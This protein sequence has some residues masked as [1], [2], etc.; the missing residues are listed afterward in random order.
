MRNISISIDKGDIMA[1]LSLAS[2]YAGARAGEPDEY[3]R[4]AATRDDRLMLERFWREC[5]GRLTTALR[6]V[7]AGLTHTPDG[8]TL[9]LE[10]SDSASEALTDELEGGA[11]AFMASAM[12]ARWFG[13][14][15]RD[16]A[17]GAAAF[18]ES[19]LTGLMERIFHRRPP[20][21]RNMVRADIRPD[22]Y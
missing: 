9:D 20:R 13:T 8:L 15:R 2:E 21:R 14:V 12:S 10:L 19:E 1:Q 16:E 17:A 4:V 18:A 3:R 7:L 5:A 11:R 6:P 22:G